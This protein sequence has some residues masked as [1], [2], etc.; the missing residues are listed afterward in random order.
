MNLEQ[1]LAHFPSH[2][3]DLKHP[4]RVRWNAQ[5]VPYIEAECAADAAYALGLVHR[6]LRA[7]QIEISLRVAQ[8]RVAE[9]LG[10]PAVGL[11]HALRVLDL[12]GAAHRCEAAL[13]DDTR[14]WVT[15]FVRGLNDGQARQPRAPREYRWLGIRPQPWTVLDVLTLGR[16]AGADVN[17]SSYLELLRQ[18]DGARK[19]W[20]WQRLRIIGGTL[21]APLAQFARAGSNSVV[22]GARRSASGAPLMAN[23]PHL[24]QTLPNFWLLAGLRYPERHMVGLMPAGL[25]FVGVGA[26]PHLAWGGTN[27]RAASSDLVD[28][29][30]LPGELLRPRVERI[31]VRGL[32]TR[33][34]VVRVSPHGPILNDA[35]LLRVRGGAV[36]LR[37]MGHQPSDE[38]GAFLRAADARDPD[39]FRRAFADFGVCAQNILFATRQ[40]HHIGHVYAAH[41]PRRRESDL[42]RPIL[43]P[44]QADAA[45]AQRWDALQLPMSVDPAEGYRVSANDRPRFHAAPL[46]MFFSEGARA[47]RLAQQVAGEGLALDDLAAL[48]TDTMVA[49]AA[50]LAAQLADRLESV[51]ADAELLRLL[52]IWD[53]DYRA[54]SR[55][56]ALFECLLGELART[57]ALH[58]GTT[59]DDEWGRHS[60]LLLS[61]LDGLALPQRER[62]L[63]QAAARGVRLLRRGLA[64][65]DL[66]RLRITHLL[67]M[68]PGMGRAF[69]VDEWGA[70][71]SRESPM[72]NSHGVVRGRH[73]VQYGAQARHLSDL[74]DPDANHFVLLG[75]NDGWIGSSGYTDQ[76][77]LWRSRRYLRMPLGAAA[78]ATEF[79]RL[80]VLSPESRS[81]AAK[82]TAPPAV[83]AAPLSE[84]AGAG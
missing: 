29:S 43:S 10:P 25:P 65:G 15:D 71:G 49:N 22:I 69:A 54:D 62:A 41:L 55:S 40:G 13:P 5:S 61:D 31:R 36:A 84:R 59:L 1:R 73:F 38:I 44:E 83:P 39:S 27:M 47:A 7:A 82:P 37:W 67:G 58:A 21:A 35:R 32:G 53:G 52:R 19:Q 66:H 76:I 57:M 68:V 79:P 16:L 63:R 24:G 46:G 18:R 3:L 17:W 56:A 2:G 77:A 70:G 14:S 48:H 20:L 34:R 51:Q 26:S 64:W 4:V 33:T 78:I 9:M 81:A 75:G 42:A 30:S 12:T 74:S 6:H 60:R 11:D 23:D 45:W 50:A 8:G 28:V 72:K 80:T